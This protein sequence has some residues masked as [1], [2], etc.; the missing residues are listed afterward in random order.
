MNILTHNSI[1]SFYPGLSFAN[2]GLWSDDITLSDE[3]CIEVGLD[4]AMISIDDNATWSKPC[5]LYCPMLWRKPLYDRGIAEFSW[6]SGVNHAGPGGWNSWWDS[7]DMRV[8]DMVMWRML[9]RCRNTLCLHAQK[10]EERSRYV[11]V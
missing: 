9:A 3:E 10:Y 1:L 5:G 8:I 11:F 4:S 2:Y 6:E 7:E